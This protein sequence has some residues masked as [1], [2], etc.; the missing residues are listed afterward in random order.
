MS[1]TPWTPGP[2]SVRKCPCGHR[3]CSQYTIS[4]QGSAGFGLAD[5]ML[6]AAA[7]DMAEALKNLIARY[8]EVVTTP[9][10]SCSPDDYDVAKARAVLAKARGQA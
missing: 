3:A 1:D 9:D 6:Y 2:I 4:T 8:V 10:C 5:A 7:P